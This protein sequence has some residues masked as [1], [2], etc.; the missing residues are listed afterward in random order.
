MIIVVI[1][2]RSNSG[3]KR[4]GQQSGRVSTQQGARRSSSQPNE[5]LAVL[6]A[7][8]GIT[9]PVSLAIVLCSVCV[10]LLTLYSYSIHSL[11]CFI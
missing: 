6:E 11:Q 1:V 3:P 8:K 7:L 9:N 5:K 10:V 2:D 4:V